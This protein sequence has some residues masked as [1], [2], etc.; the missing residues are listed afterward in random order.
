MKTKLLLLSLLFLLFSCAKGVKTKAVFNLKSLNNIAGDISVISQNGLVIFGSNDKGHRFAKVMNTGD[1]FDHELDNGLWTFKAIA[2][3]DPQSNF[4][5]LNATTNTF[6]GVPNCA[7][8]TLPLNG[9]EVSINLSL[10]NSTCAD[11]SFGPHFVGANN[12]EI[13]FYGLKDII[14]CN[15]LGMTAAASF[16]ADCAYNL[17]GYIAGDTTQVYKGLAASYKIMVR[18]FYAGPS[19]TVLGNVP[20][21]SGCISTSSVATGGSVID[22]NFVAANPNNDTGFQIPSG[23]GFEFRLQVF[24]E[25]NCA[26]KNKEIVLG[27]GLGINTE[28][29][30][31]LDDGANMKKLFVK[32]IAAD[33]CP[34]T[35]TTSPF[36]GGNGSTGLPY[37]IC[38]PRQLNEI[39]GTASTPA[40]YITDSFKLLADLDMNS[41]TEAIN[42][43]NTYHGSNS[44]DIDG[45]ANFKPIGFDEGQTGQASCTS[46]LP[47]AFSGNFDGE[48]YTIKNLRF[49]AYNISTGACGKTG[50][51]A[52]L[53]GSNIARL[54]LKNVEVDKAA[55]YVGIIAGQA[56][57]SSIYEV[58]IDN[59]RI[60]AEEATNGYVG[61]LVGNIVSTTQ[62]KNVNL[63]GLYLDASKTSAGNLSTGVGGIAGSINNGVSISDV[64][65]RGFVQANWQGAGGP[66]YAQN[67]GGIIGAILGTGTV[68][69]A[70]FYGVVRGDQIVGG[71]AGSGG[72]AGTA[73]NFFV[74]GQ[75]VSKPVSGTCDAKVG[76][77]F[78][79]AGKAITFAFFGGRLSY[80]VEGCT[81]P[82]MANYGGIVGNLPTGS[83]TVSYSLAPYS[84][85]NGLPE[86]GILPTTNYDDS[87]WRSTSWTS[88]ISLDTA[89]AWN[90]VEG[91]F[92][93][94]KIDIGHPCSE[95]DNLSSV[96]T[97]VASFGRGS[98]SNPIVLCRRSQFDEIGSYLGLAYKLEDSI[99]IM[100]TSGSFG[101]FSGILDGRGNSIYGL[102]NMLFSSNSNMIKDINFIAIA[103]SKTGFNNIGLIANNSGTITNANINGYVIGDDTVGMLAA[104][105]TGTIKKVKVEGSVNG[106]LQNIG[107]IAGVNQGSINNAYVGG[108][109]TISSDYT[110]STLTNIGGVV[111]LNDTGATIEKVKARNRIRLAGAMGALDDEY[112]GGVAGVN[113]GTISNIE[114]AQFEIDDN[115]ASPLTARTGYV[116]GTEPGGSSSKGKIFLSNGASSELYGD[117]TGM[118]QVTFDQYFLIDDSVTPTALDTTPNNASEFTTI[119][120]FDTAGWS[121]E[122]EDDGM[123]GIN[124]VFLDYYLAILNGQT[125]PANMPA[126]E[127]KSSGNIDEKIRLFDVD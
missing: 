118:T 115:T 17:A 91:D 120:E 89:T 26:G 3:E 111:G 13:Q 88:G 106:S 85:P 70:A 24:Y 105:N 64:V 76:G 42:G 110:A 45:G 15:S 125:P 123:G 12:S 1:T 71:I 48:Q 116:A 86:G 126:W 57:A 108:Y 74:D 31:A 61:G 55:S 77:I 32:T 117:D 47:T 62:I 20:L 80:D 21:E 98:V 109:M 60:R 52:E 30:K 82:S 103:I 58:N 84:S 104:T 36:A 33:V 2:W 6:M 7:I 53:N 14:S 114:V 22:A 38:N 93:R 113:N 16:A 27:N 29:A 44:H 5:T 99:T 39:Y 122:P 119:S 81:A 49:D 68:N 35:A 9:S 4:G 56:Q 127:Y 112:L 59:A 28:F 41:E 96:A 107:M 65:V 19:N 63:N 75:I 101:S 54:N 102:S 11:A 25:D 67:V 100:P 69:N 83:V 46:A 18:P 50:I 8:A 66:S 10:R 97:Q 78:G 34:N 79:E 37:L 90:H 51:F 43:S 124:Q 73:T 121:I 23:A 92:P 94:L 40:P 87:E 72:G 95:T